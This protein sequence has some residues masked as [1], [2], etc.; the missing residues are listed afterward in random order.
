MPSRNSKG[1]LFLSGPVTERHDEKYFCRKSGALLFQAENG[2]N[3]KVLSRN[4]GILMDL[5]KQVRRESG[6]QN[7]SGSVTKG[8][9]IYVGWF[10]YRPG[11]WGIG[12]RSQMGTLR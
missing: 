9:R 7:S 6:L 8:Q 11:F 10:A 5:N 1:R 3:D 12:D 4:R 2:G